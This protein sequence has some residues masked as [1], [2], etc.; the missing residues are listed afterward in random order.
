MWDACIGREKVIVED[1]RSIFAGELTRF[2]SWPEDLLCG[3]LVDGQVIDGFEFC[4]F[5]VL[6]DDGVNSAGVWLCE[7]LALLILC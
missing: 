4:A 5:L 3:S 6:W 2:S 1:L 7:T